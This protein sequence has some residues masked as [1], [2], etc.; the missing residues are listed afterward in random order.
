MSDS[1]LIALIGFAFVSTATPGPNN[2]M[3]LASGANFGYRRSLPHM[4]GIVVGMLVLFSA[5]G[6]GL[7]AIFEVLP[8]ADMVLKTVAVGY[9]LWLAWKIANAGAPKAASAEGRPLTLLQAAGFQW[10]NPKAWTMALSGLSLYAPDHSLPAVAAV[11]LAFALVAFP[12]ISLWTALGQQ[13]RRLLTSPARLRAF[14]ITM[15]LLL[16]ASLY[17]VVMTGL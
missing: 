14:N 2:M 9:M 15:A 10:V 6:G 12:S 5:V 3:L 16:V 17:P 7:M 4:F 1:L 11:V 8:Q 13:I